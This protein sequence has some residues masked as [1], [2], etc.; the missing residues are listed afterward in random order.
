[1]PAPL[2]AV[3]AEIGRSSGFSCSFCAGLRI[4]ACQAQERVADG[5]E[6]PFP[7]N[8]KIGTAALKVQ[9]KCFI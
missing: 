1:M 6:A 7:F 9:K 2:A 8:G 5:V 4:D 3:S